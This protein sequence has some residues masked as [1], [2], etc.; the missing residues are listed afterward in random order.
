MSDKIYV[1]K[2]KTIDHIYNI[3]NENREVTIS[4]SL[5]EEV[6]NTQNKMTVDKISEGTFETIV[7]KG[8]GKFAVNFEKVKKLIKKGVIK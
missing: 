2:E 6:I 8:M 3:I 4:K 5:I 1:S 7:W